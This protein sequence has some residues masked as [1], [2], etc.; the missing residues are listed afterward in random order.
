[1]SHVIILMS[2]ANT[3]YK[4]FGSYVK[5]VSKP[6]KRPSTHKIGL[7]AYFPTGYCGIFG[8]FQGKP[9]ETLFDNKK[10]CMM[11]F[12]IYIRNYTSNAN[13]KAEEYVDKS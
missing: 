1:M 10:K 13:D 4:P 2:L 7:E 6:D 5:A 8:Y 11:I 12:I 3:W 9:N